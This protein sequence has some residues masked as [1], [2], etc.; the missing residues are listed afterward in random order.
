MAGARKVLASLAVGISGLD[1]G[2]KFAYFIIKLIF[3]FQANHVVY[4]SL[5]RTFTVIHKIRSFAMF[6]SELDYVISCQFIT[7]NDFGYRI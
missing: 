7:V 4:V 6:A 1:D 5:Y 2:L 3:N